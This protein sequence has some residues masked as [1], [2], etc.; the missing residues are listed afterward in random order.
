MNIKQIEEIKRLPLKEILES[1]YGMKFNSKGHALCPL[2]ND[3][4]PSFHASVNNKGYWI[5]HC[6]GC[7][8]GGDYIDFRRKMDKT[9]F[10][11]T[12]RNIQSENGINPNSQV[13]SSKNEKTPIAEYVYQNEE[14][15]PVY[16][17]LKFRNKNYAF[18]RLENGKWKFRLNG[19]KRVLY[20][21]PEILKSPYV[22]LV[23]GEKDCET[24]R[25]LDCVATTAG[26]VNDWKEN[27]TQYFKDK[28]VFI[29]FDVGNEEVAEK[30]ALDLSTVTKTLKILNLPGLI[31]REQDITDWFEMMGDLSNEVKKNRLFKICDGTPDF[32]IRE[33]TTPIETIT[34]LPI[35][36]ITEPPIETIR[37]FRA[38]NIPSREV[39]LQSWIE[40]EA[41]TIL[42]GEQKVG[43][44]IITLNVA[45]SLAL[46]NDFLGFEVPKP[47]RVLLYQ[48][49]ISAS[50]MK[51]RTEKILGDESSS[52]LDNFLIKNTTGNSIKITKEEDRKLL[53]EEIAKEQPDLVIFDPLS[54]FHDK[55]ENDEQ[56]MSKVLDIFFDIMHK[57]KVAI[58][59]IHHYAK[60][61]IA[62]RDGSHLLRGHSV[63]GDRP[64]A[65]IVFNKVYEKYKKAPLHQAYNCYAEI[66]F[67]LRNDAAPENLIVERNPENLWYSVFDLDERFG[68][69]IL[70]EQVKKIVEENDGEMLQSDLILILIEMA[71]RSV[72]FKA[73]SEAKEKGYIESEPLSGKGKPNLIKLKKR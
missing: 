23:E 71:S 62:K 67:V 18:E 44:S 4:N 73:I 2:H 40:R 11:Y 61:S 39:F 16:R 8:K 53:Y 63:L 58:L 55:K 70:P 49:E 64:D 10:N 31:E 25:H 46:G 43:K 17:K 48:Q 3:N 65:I 50:A 52:L 60:P 54:T 69:K 36:A 33:S 15:D 38:R 24:L 14:G 19:T 12:I 59:L 68:K 21:L 51:E 34:E 57:F 37:A 47:R 56:D 7:K 22:F 72:V 45:T 20:N 27:F 28:G 42:G 13:S 30:V 5:W 32:E 26:S 6:F 41:L 66:Q 1:K 35:E 29:C 9:D